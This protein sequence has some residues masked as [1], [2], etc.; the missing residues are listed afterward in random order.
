MKFFADQVNKE[1]ELR[2]K[3]TNLYGE[4]KI[5]IEI[6][7]CKWCGFIDDKEMVDQCDNDSWCPCCGMCE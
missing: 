6:I 3:K 2:S 5:V 7:I 4:G 1:H